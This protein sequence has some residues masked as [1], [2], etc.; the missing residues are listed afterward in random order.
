MPQ[1]SHFVIYPLAQSQKIQIRLANSL[2]LKL[3]NA[4]DFNLF[5][6][7]SNLA[8]KRKVLKLKSQQNHLI[9]IK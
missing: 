7:S 1:T 8:E 9:A 5:F 3:S 6:Q 4:E 2:V